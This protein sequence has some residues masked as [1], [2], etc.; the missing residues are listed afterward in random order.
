MLKTPCRCEVRA[1]EAK[2]AEAEKG[3]SDAGRALSKY[4]VACEDRDAAE[5]RLAALRPVVRAA[6][7]VD[8]NAI[9]A[10]IHALDPALISWAKGDDQ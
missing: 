7:A 6:I 1:L 8:E 2:L 3:W 4:T 5:S 10:A 9:E